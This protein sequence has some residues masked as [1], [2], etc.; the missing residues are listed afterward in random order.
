MVERKGFGIGLRLDGQRCSSQCTRGA[1]DQRLLG[2]GRAVIAELCRLLPL[3]RSWW[4]AV[5]LVWICILRTS[6]S[7]NQGAA[8]APSSCKTRGSPHKIVSFHTRPRA[9]FPLGMPEDL[10]SQRICMKLNSFLSL[11]GGKSPSE[12][13]VWKNQAVGENWAQIWPCSNFSHW[14]KGQLKQVLLGF[15]GLPLLSQHCPL[16]AES[17]CKTGCS[18]EL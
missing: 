5:H 4:T 11:K 16:L 13:R 1:W 9:A 17:S 8:E 14:Q 10:D 2:K 7:D 12:T 18:M 6:N 3:Y 15:A